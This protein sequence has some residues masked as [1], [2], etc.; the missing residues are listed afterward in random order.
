MLCDLDWEMAKQHLIDN[1]LM[2]NQCARPK[3]VLLHVV[4]QENEKLK[5][6]INDQIKE[7]TNLIRALDLNITNKTRDPVVIG[8]TTSRDLTY[9]PVIG[10]AT[11]C[12]LKCSPVIGRSSSRDLLRDYD[13]GVFSDEEFGESEEDMTEPYSES[14]EDCGSDRT[15]DK[16]CKI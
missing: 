14:F 1:N 6:Q 13:S 8:R 5:Q 15:H 7:N 3:I 4:L 2:N 12:D 9:S 16:Q 11:S 10:T